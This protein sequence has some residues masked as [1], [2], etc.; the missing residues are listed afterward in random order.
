MQREFT[1]AAGG[2]E[3]LIREGQPLHLHP[4][5]RPD[6]PAPKQPVP[7]TPDE[8]GY[9]PDIDHLKTSRVSMGWSK[10]SQQFYLLFVM[11]PDDENTSIAQYR[12]RAIQTGGWM[13]ADEQQF[14][15]KF[16]VWGAV[17]SDG[18]NAAQLAELQT[19]GNCVVWDHLISRNGP[20][21]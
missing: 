4:Y 2:A 8:A 16:G 15:Q 1:T 6:D 14:W 17:N 18:G 3:C 7:S 12:S 20:K 10:D 11:E 5:P 21:E 9:I 13:V 19:S